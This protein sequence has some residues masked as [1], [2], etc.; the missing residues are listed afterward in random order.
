MKPTLITLNFLVT[1][2]HVS[3]A[4]VPTSST[5]NHYHDCNRF[6]HGK[7]YFER[8]HLSS[9]S[10]SS[11]RLYK[12]WG[13]RWNPTPDSDYYR[14]GNDGNG[15]LD[16]YDRIHFDGSKRRSKFIPVFGLTRVFSLQRFLVVSFV[17]AILI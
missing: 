17:K 6:F 9:K 13:P 14:R 16:G 1:T 2:L 12:K 10:A 15:D 3:T 11:T 7:T 5:R 4:F 8:K